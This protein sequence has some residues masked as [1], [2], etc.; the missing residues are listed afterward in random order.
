MTRCWESRELFLRTGRRRRSILETSAPSESFLKRRRPNSSA[1]AWTCSKSQR[2]RWLMSADLKRIIT[3]SIV[4]D[5][6][7]V[8]GGHESVGH[9]MRPVRTLF[10]GPRQLFARSGAVKWWP[11]RLNR[12]TRKR[13]RQVVAVG[14]RKHGGRRQ[15]EPAADDGSTPFTEPSA[16]TLSAYVLL[17]L[18]NLWN[19][20]Q[21][22]KIF[23]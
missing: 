2:R 21:K 4:E 18:I 7:A 14:S 11:S 22:I 20:D 19:I 23:M 12:R 13:R 17:T 6:E 3:T 8:V 5:E 10:M 16:M 15:K 9:G 1:D